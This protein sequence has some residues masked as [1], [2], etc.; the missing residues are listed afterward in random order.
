MEEIKVMPK[1]DW[2]SWDD[3]HELLMAA[4]KRNIEQGM[5]MKIPQ[6]SGSELE[7]KVGE[8][9]RCFVAL[10]GEKLV[11][12]TSVRFYKGKSWFDKNKLVAHSMLS[13]ILPKYQGIGITEE[14]NE[15]RDAYIQEIGAKMI[16][17]DT[18]ENNVIVLKNA[19]RNGFVNVAYH[20]YKSDH[21]SIIFVKWLEKCPFNK[22]Y[23]NRK[24]RLS[25]MIT[26]MQYKLGG[27]ER[28]KLLSFI[29]D[30]VRRI[31]NVY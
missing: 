17:A 24:F 28:S 1:P 16:H 18:A 15:L 26:R 27:I 12:T 3:I 4:H 19:Q 2:V 5:T 13:A 23:I 9:G 8:N 20:A 25:R 11:G 31:L 21:Y 29:C 6:L 30:G 7:K 10:A 14:L 22:K